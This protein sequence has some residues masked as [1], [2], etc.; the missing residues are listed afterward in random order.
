MSYFREQLEEYL[1]HLYIDA[2]NVLDI[3]GAS[4]P[5]KDRV[6]GW[7]VKNYFIADNLLE[8]GKTN[9]IADVEKDDF[10]MKVID[11]SGI[12]QFDEIFCLE[13]MEYVIDPMM[14]IRNIFTLLAKDGIARI[15]FPFVYP[16]HE[17]KEFDSLR[18][19]KYGIIRMIEKYNF[20]YKIIARRAKNDKLVSY[21]YDDGM[22]PAKG[23]AHDITGYIVELKK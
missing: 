16:I 22:H 21:Y 10:V 11:Q 8:K 15:S 12:D 1:S 3:G 13:V 18:Y 7:N 4:N 14:V 2:Y 9:I 20:K 19:T 17:P 23:E 6:I 5:V